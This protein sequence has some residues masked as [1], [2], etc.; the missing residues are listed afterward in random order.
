MSV[1]VFSPGMTKKP[2]VPAGTSLPATLAAW[3]K[4]ITVAL[5]APAR[6][7]W[8]KGTRSPQIL[9]PFTAGR[10]KA[11][12]ILLMPISWDTVQA[13]L[14]RR[15][16]RRTGAGLSSARRGAARGRATSRV[17]RSNLRMGVSWDTAVEGSTSTRWEEEPA[18]VP[19]EGL[20]DLQPEAAAGPAAEVP[21][22]QGRPEGQGEGHREV[23]D[24]DEADAEQAPEDLLPGQGA[25]EPEGGGAQGQRGRLEGDVADFRM[26]AREG[27]GHGHEDQQ[28]AQGRV[29]REAR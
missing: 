9:R 4:V 7:T 27:E 8:P 17:G 10:A 25:L 13:G 28:G 21:G 2:Y 19:V 18:G 24:A 26:D 15:G 14:R 29:A 11:R 20:E 16:V 12:S 1:Q 5:L 22:P 6:Q 23:Q 3:L